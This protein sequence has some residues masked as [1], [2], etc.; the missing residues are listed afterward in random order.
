MLLISQ[1]GKRIIKSLMMKRSITVS[2][3]TEVHGNLDK[4]AIQISQVNTKHRLG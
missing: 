3:N 2:A 1:A 4:N